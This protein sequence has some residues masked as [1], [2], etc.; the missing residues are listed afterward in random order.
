MSVQFVFL[1]IQGRSLLPYMAV[2]AT[3]VSS[4]KEFPAETADIGRFWFASLRL[5]Y[6]FNLRILEVE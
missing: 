6:L 2:H 3:E 4:L 1:K 5:E